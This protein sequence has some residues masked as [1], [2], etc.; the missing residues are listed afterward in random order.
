M[1]LEN[2]RLVED[3]V[4]RLLVHLGVKLLLLIREEQDFNVR[5]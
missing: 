5:I 3:G 4:Q 2:K 1:Y